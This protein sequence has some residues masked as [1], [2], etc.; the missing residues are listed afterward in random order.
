MY[1]VTHLIFVLHIDVS[2]IE[3]QLSVSFNL[4]KIFEA[5]RH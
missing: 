2:Y 4:S 5:Y 3:M 1:I